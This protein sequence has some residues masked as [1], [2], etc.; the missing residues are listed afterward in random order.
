MLAPESILF[1][2]VLVLSLVG[3]FLIRN[4]LI[5]LFLAFII[6][7]ALSPLVAAIQKR[8]RLNRPLSILLAYCCVIAVIAGCVSIIV[9]PLV[10]QVP[11]LIN[12]L[13]KLMA[14]ANIPFLNDLANN[15]N[16]TFSELGN[17]LNQVSSSVGV[18]ISLVSS[19]FSGI[20]TFFMLLV[21]SFYL[22]MER[23]RLYK[24]ASWFTRDADH[25]NKVRLF[26]DELEFQL[27]GWVRSQSILMVLMGMVTYIGLFLL[28]V[29]YALP[30][31]L[32]AGLL[33]ILPNIGPTIAAI[34]ALIL[35]FYA[36][37]PF[38]FVVTLLF[39]VIIQALEN[40]LFVPKILQQNVDVNPLV[41]ILVILIGIELGGVTGAVLS[42]PTYII[43]RTIYS[44]LAR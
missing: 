26:I 12:E 13:Y 20:L 24:K 33:E 43:L 11:L 2:V 40:Y 9:P 30:L 18:V 25:I 3:I 44:K 37:G 5:L 17:V 34:P 36:G 32:L 38:L 29:P 1:F 4:I 41:S 14:G 6:M 22:L 7:V 28:N 35:A 39:Y 15:L 23:P 16:P 19:T 8:L 10:N 27:G 21:L 31:A 42:V